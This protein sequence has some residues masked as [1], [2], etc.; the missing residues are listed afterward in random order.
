MDA[1]EPYEF[2]EATWPQTPS[3]PFSRPCPKLM[4]ETVTLYTYLVRDDNVTYKKTIS[5]SD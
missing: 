5:Q 3:K 4:Q 1:N 2:S